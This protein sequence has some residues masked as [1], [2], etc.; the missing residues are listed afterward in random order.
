M[1]QR[2]D[3]QSEQ[4]RTRRLLAIC[5]S[6]QESAERPAATSVALVLRIDTRSQGVP[7]LDPTRRS[8]KVALETFASN[9]VRSK[10]KD[11]LIREVQVWYS[12]STRDLKG[13]LQLENDQQ[14]SRQKLMSRLVRT[15]LSDPNQDNLIR[16]LQ[17]SCHNRYTL[18]SEEAQ[19]KIHSQGNTKG[20]ES[21][22][23]SEKIQCLHCLRCSAPGN[24]Y[25]RCGTIF[26]KEHANSEAVERSPKLNQ[27]RFDL[28]TIPHVA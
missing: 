16:E 27:Q 25:C 5:S 24:V 7:E 13:V 3:W 26:A 2:A 15:I 21:C 28:L 8:P 9:A 17:D 18:L 4:V 20:F 23:L 11:N 19:Q 6:E 12:E 14:E 10:Q 22:V 1:V